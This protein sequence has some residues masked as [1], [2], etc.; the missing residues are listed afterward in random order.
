MFAE[1]GRKVDSILLF[2]VDDEELL[3]RLSGR[4]VC[5]TCQTPYRGREPGTICPKCGGRLVRRPDDEPEAIRNR[6]RVYREQTAPV[7]EWARQHGL[8]IVEIDATGEVD[9]ITDRALKALAS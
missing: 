7:I 9:T 2:D 5:E 3:R 6:L 1:R 4:T 8:P